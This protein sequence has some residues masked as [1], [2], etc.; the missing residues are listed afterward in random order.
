[1][2]STE[3]Q[4]NVDTKLEEGGELNVEGMWRGESKRSTSSQMQ[5]QKKK[6]KFVPFFAFSFLK[7]I[8]V[9]FFSFCFFCLRRGKLPPFSTLFFS[10]VFF[11]FVFFFY[12]I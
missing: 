11:F 4:G 12:F 6:G 3:L 2:S 7:K 9:F 8:L 10:M 5:K 1:L